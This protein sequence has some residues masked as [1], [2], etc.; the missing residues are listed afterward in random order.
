M[1]Q[2]W[3]TSHKTEHGARRRISLAHAVFR[4]ALAEAR[5]LQL[6]A[7]N[8]TELVKVPKPVKREISPLTVDQARAFHSSEYLCSA[9]RAR[10]FCAEMML[11]ASDPYKQRARA[12]A[13]L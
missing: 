6:V 10:L 3:L 9:P 4:S 13:S 2:G 12:S 8:V 11:I 1:V 5:R 7:I